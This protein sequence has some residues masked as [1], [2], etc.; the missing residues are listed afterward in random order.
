[1]DYTWYV[2]VLAID[3]GKTGCRVLRREEAARQWLGQ[4]S[5]ALGMSHPDGPAS[6]MAAIEGALAAGA[7]PDTG[8]DTVCLGAAGVAAA[9]R[10]AAEVARMLADR[11]A[12]RALVTSDSV[13][14]HAGA[15]GG[16]NGVVLAVGTGS[17]A[18]TFDGQGALVQVDGWGQTLGDEGSGWW[19]GREGLMAACRALDGRGPQTALRAVAEEDFGDL[20]TLPSRL[21]DAT[22]AIPVLASFA[23]QV[24]VG[25]RGGD[26]V[27][28]EILARATEAL[29]ATVRA[30]ARATAPAGDATPGGVRGPGGGR[31][32][33]SAPGAVVRCCMIGGLSAWPERFRAALSQ[34]AQEG[35]SFTLEWVAPQGTS[36]EGAALIAARTDLPHRGVCTTAAP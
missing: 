31:D 26:G 16:A 22:A 27:A 2:T 25:A 29:G 15:L 11:F 36:L 18:I 28:T 9:P 13:S 23:P 6:A 33:G 7:V 17:V 8:V 5:G 14:S 34:R 10:A 1:M 35:T 12:A 30:A 32:A 21:G 20:R 4:G 3:L 19:I 24:L